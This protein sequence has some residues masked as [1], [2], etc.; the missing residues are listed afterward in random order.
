MTPRERYQ[1]DI[2]QGLILPDSAQQQ[3][4]EVL[5]SLHQRLGSMEAGWSRWL[6]RALP[7]LRQ[8]E[9]IKGIYC[10]G[11]VGRGK[12][13]LMDIFYEALPG[14]RKL[15][16]HFH[17]FMQSIHRDLS[18]L[19][20]QKNPLDR[21]GEDLAAR[22][23]VICLDEF[24]VSDIGDAMILATLLDA[25]LSRR[26]VLVTTSNIAPDRLYENG[27]QRARFLPAI[28]LLKEHC[29]VHELDAGV[30]Y[31]LRSLTAAPLYHW[32]LGE[33]ADGS[34]KDSFDQLAPDL[35]EAREEEVIEVLGRPIPSRRSADDVIWFDFSMLCAGP[36]S[37]YDY[38]E[39]ARLYHAV[40]LSN[41]PVL[42]DA[43]NDQAR[44]FINLVDEFY[45][46]NVKLI[47]SAAAPLEGLYRGTG[48]AREFARTRSR[49]QE[50]RSREYLGRPH[51]P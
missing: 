27:L 18:E 2:Q 3:M 8:A 13:Y 10:W 12:T 51:R 28:A 14:E 40:L 38:I 42:D 20:G 44:R 50:M 16:T 9:P 1:Q 4:V 46:R 34:L 26:V 47:L 37:V 35:R 11:G 15:R 31:R 30:D 17:R 48:L 36:R 5:Q 6:D 32:P 19:K 45:D 33:A 7:F 21:I 22:Y 24:F 43:Q 49:L 39:I 25:L 29:L 41:V 23:R